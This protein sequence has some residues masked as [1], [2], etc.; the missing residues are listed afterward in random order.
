MELSSSTTEAS[1][2]PQAYTLLELIGTGSF[3]DVWRAVDVTT[4]QE[5]AIKIVDLEDM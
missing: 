3:G 1:H 2:S 4:Q 5:V